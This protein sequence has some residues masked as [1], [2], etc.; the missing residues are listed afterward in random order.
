MTMEL[1]VQSWGTNSEIGL[2]MQVLKIIL[3]MQN[4][5]RY[6]RKVRLILPWLITNI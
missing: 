2:K 5:L 3:Q 6:P 4:G 1:Q